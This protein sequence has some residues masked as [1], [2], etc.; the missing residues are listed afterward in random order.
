MAEYRFRRSSVILGLLVACGGS[1]DAGPNDA[2]VDASP[3]VAIDAASSDAT[4]DAAATVALG[5]TIHFLQTG[6]TVR[7]K[8]GASAVDVSSNGTFALPRVP[9]GASYDLALETTAGNQLCSIWSG[10][11][12][13]AN[14]DVTDVVLGCVA[15]TETLSPVASAQTYTTLSPT[16]VDF[17]GNAPITLTL[18]NDVATKALLTLSLPQLSAPLKG[19]AMYAIFVDGKPVSESF[20]ED[21]SSGAGIPMAG[22]AVVDLA[23]GSHVVTAKWRTVYLDTPPK[24]ATFD[25]SKPM[26]LAAV[27]LGSLSTFAGASTAIANQTPALN[28]TTLTVTEPV[29]LSATLAA[30][31]PLFALASV[32]F[33]G[34]QAGVG[35]QVVIDYDGA[36]TGTQ[37]ISSWGERNSLVVPL[38]VP[39]ATAGTHTIASLVGPATTGTYAKG[40]TSG[41]NTAIAR[42]D[43]LAFKPGATTLRGAATGDKTTTSA[44]FS[45]LDATANLSLTSTKESLVLVAFH[46]AATWSTGNNNTGELAIDVDGSVTGTSAVTSTDPTR[47]GMTSP[48]FFLLRLAAGAHVLKPVFRSRGDGAQ[49]ATN[50]FHVVDPSV[51]AIVLE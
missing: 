38:L 10:G 9:I 7:I 20:F 29:A 27:A 1:D 15:A 4:S 47:R 21:V 18:E 25:R 50:V 31:A 41:K 23:A 35:V 33:L 24:P 36:R 2:A 30:P 51:S 19:A 22:Y 32:P 11:K 40:D 16:Y 39:S 8:N 43:L 37:H 17:D 48:T 49:G 14:T 6:T 12:G 44:T 34:C 26:R 28:L 46:Q 45:E 13:T 5:G 3:D 42:H